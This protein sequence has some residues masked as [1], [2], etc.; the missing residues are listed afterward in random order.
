[1]NSVDQFIK[2]VRL[3]NHVCNIKGLR[4]QVAKLQGLE[5]L[6]LWQRLHKKFD[7]SEKP[8]LFW[9]TGSMNTLANR[10]MLQVRARD[11]NKTQVCYW[12]LFK[13][14]AFRF[15]LQLVFHRV[16]FRKT[17]YYCIWGIFKVGICR[18]RELIYTKTNLG[19]LYFHRAYNYT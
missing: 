18:Y 11:K 9:L 6:S 14:R 10:K 13:T 1:M 12:D 8:W 15:K 17:G 4:H 5:N 7:Q 2:S 3:K 16:G 19:R